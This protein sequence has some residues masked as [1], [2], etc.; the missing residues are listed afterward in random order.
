MPEDLEV[1]TPVERG[2]RVRWARELVEPNRAQFARKLQVDT[3][4][5]RNIENGSRNPSLELLERICHALRISPDYVVKG[6]FTGVDP[7]MAALLAAAHPELIQ[8]SNPFGS[9]RTDSRAS[10]YQ[11]PRIL[12]SL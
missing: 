12:A 5:I 10:T 11:L 3:S 4:T 1:S 8:K 7:E 9:V 2:L 6:R